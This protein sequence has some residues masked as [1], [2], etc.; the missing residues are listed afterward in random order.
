MR[1]VVY[2]TLI[3]A[4][5]RSHENIQCILSEEDCMDWDDLALGDAHDN[6]VQTSNPTTSGSQLQHPTMHPLAVARER[7]AKKPR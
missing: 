6:R 5:S 3:F 1:S 7:N 4:D 2:L